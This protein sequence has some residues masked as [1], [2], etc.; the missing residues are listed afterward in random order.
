L[1]VRNVENGSVPID[2]EDLLRELVLLDPGSAQPAA[3]FASPG[4]SAAIVSQVATKISVQ[5]TA[6]WA[7]WDPRF[8][9]GP[10]ISKSGIEGTLP[11]P[12]SVSPPDTPW[13]PIH[14]DWE[15]Q[16]I[17][18][19]KPLEDWDLGEI[20]YSPGTTPPAQGALTMRG[21]THLTGGAG[22]VAALTIRKAL[23]QAARGGGAAS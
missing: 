10:L 17:P 7:T 3:Q 2:C 21:R 11:S 6:W 16:F 1:V 5:Q 8:D 23:E 12:V 13:F 22:K 15:I 14:L 4:A 20:D 9:S 18:S 19:E